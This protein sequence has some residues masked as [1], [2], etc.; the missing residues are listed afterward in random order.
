MRPT[1]PLPRPRLIC[2]DEAEAFLNPIPDCGVCVPVLSIP[3]RRAVVAV[4]TIA[5]QK[6][7]FNYACSPRQRNLRI[8]DAPS[9]ILKCQ[10][11]RWAAVST[12]HVQSKCYQ[13]ITTSQ[14]LGTAT[15]LASFFVTAV[16]WALL[17]TRH[18]FPVHPLFGNEYIDMQT[19]TNEGGVEC[20][21]G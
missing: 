20:S 18:G 21:T 14:N 5:S 15:A 17:K 9:A 8:T 11:A 13:C 7:G 12:Y 3:I 10:C 1:S 16:I 2:W 19:Q 4:M 6:Q